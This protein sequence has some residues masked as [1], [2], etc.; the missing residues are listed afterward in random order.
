MIK[1]LILSIY[2]LF[3]ADFVF[4]QS[5]QKYVTQGKNDP[6]KITY[7]QSGILKLQSRTAQATVDLRKDL[8]GCLRLFDGSVSTSRFT[9]DAISIRVLDEIIRGDKFFLVLQITTNGA[10]NVQGMCGAGREVAVYWF[11][12]DA[13]LRRE[14][15]QHELIS[16]CR[17]SIALE[18]PEDKHPELQELKLKIKDGKLALQYEKYDY[19][20]KENNKSFSLLYD[21]KAPENGLLIKEDTKSKEK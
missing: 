9:T 7:R 13:A 10:C 2:I 14:K 18:E 15:F 12:F 11:Q 1:L 5:P 4:A 6:V 21:R 20:H 17:Q 8:D 16:S 19:S 3:A